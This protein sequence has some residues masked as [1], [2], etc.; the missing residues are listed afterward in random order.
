MDARA[1]GLLIVAGGVALV[2]VGLMVMGGAL[3]R[4]EKLSAR[5][6]DI[7]SYMYLASATLKRYEDE[8]DRTIISVRWPKI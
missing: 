8:Q 4:R 6:G 5:L 7:L 3:K 2:V 1:L